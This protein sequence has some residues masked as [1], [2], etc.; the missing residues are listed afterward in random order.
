MAPRTSDRQVLAS[1]P[2]VLSKL[3]R[4]VYVVVG[5]N[6]RGTHHLDVFSNLVRHQLAFVPH[7]RADL[8]ALFGLIG[9]YAVLTR[10]PVPQP[11][12]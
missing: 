2:R 7:A 1:G 8:V 4:G 10:P 5:M 6:E 9:C 11:V 3:E 12:T